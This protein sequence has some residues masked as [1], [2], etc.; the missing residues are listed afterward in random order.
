MVAEKETVSVAVV[1]TKYSDCI[2]EFPIVS[3]EESTIPYLEYGS[4]DD[5]KIDG[6][7]L[8]EVYAPM[9]DWGCQY[10]IDKVG[11]FCQ[12]KTTVANQF[13]ATHSRSLGK[14]P[15][16][17]S[18]HYYPLL[19]VNPVYYKIH[20][21]SGQYWFPRLLLSTRLTSEG[22]VVVGRLLGNRWLQRL[23]RREIKR[24]QNAGLLYKVLPQEIIHYN[25]HFPD[26][27]TLAGEGFTSYDQ[28]RW[29]RPRM[30]LKY[31]KIWNNHIQ[32][33][34]TFI[35]THQ[36]ETDAKKWIKDHTCPLPN[37]EQVKREHYT[38]GWANVII[39]PPSLEQIA[40]TEFDPWEYCS[41]WVRLHRPND[42]DKPHFP[43]MYL[44]YPNP[45]AMR[46]R[47]YPES[48]GLEE[49]QVKLDTPRRTKHYL[50]TP[51]GWL[52]DITVG[53]KEWK[54]IYY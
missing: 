27:E 29:K 48:F 47:P 14:T 3:R 21:H 39:P 38:R 33:R 36:K 20:S 24:C 22:L 6:S 31:W 35:Q 1:P 25:F 42:V 43:P 32:T 9:R 7:D 52:Q 53:N 34:K 28:I 12:E 4:D 17:M 49:Q 30:Y 44:D 51:E 19:E 13:C 11:D 46:H 37:W 45:M 16:K 8:V 26:V 2:P 15:F 50:K 18:P 54:E 10:F 23:T 5:D 40:Q 41:E